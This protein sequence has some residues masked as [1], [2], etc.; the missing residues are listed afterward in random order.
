M[1]DEDQRTTIEMDMGTPRSS[2]VPP[3]KKRGRR[4]KKTA[5]PPQQSE[6]GMEMDEG[7]Q[8]EKK[9]PA[10]KRGRP[11]KKTKL[12]KNVKKEPASPNP[13]EE[14]SSSAL[15]EQLNTSDSK[16]KVVKRRPRGAGGCRKVSKKNGVGETLRAVVSSSFVCYLVRLLYYDYGQAT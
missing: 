11:P 7:V 10:L 6:E 13:M 2:R 14:A 12:A 1:D 15:Q 3:G 8:E 16:P 4:S 5:Q 9:K